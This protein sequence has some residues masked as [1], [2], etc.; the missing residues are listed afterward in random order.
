[1]PLDKDRKIKKVASIATMYQRRQQAAQAIK[2]II[3]QVDQIVVILN[4]R[5]SENISQWKQEI[6]QPKATYIVSDNR[7]GDAERHLPVTTDK[8]YYF[9][10]DDDLIY[11]KDYV[12]KLIKGI[13]TYRSL[14]TLHGKYFPRVKI[15]NYYT[16]IRKLANS[17]KCLSLQEEDYEVTVPGS[18]VMA[19]RGDLIDL[20]YS[21]F[22]EKN[23]ADIEV[24]R[25]AYQQRER[26]VCL[27]HYAGY[28]LYNDVGED[29]I[30][31]WHYNDCDRQTE[32]MNLI[33]NGG[34]KRI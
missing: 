2:S 15:K 29:T 31:N 3:S 10:L 5:G 4:I 6:N 1:M 16:D 28:I 27:A 12:Q 19:W 8:V 22:N 9:T 7:L 26:I 13:E 14:V 30:W 21:L 17:Y 32:I 20:R 25:L 11:P 34:L 33:L 23:M 24:A 18:G